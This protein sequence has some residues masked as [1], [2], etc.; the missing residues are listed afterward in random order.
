[1]E[2]SCPALGC[3]TI[4]AALSDAESI[5]N[6]S[7]VDLAT[8]E[9]QVTYNDPDGSFGSFAWYADAA[10]TTPLNAATAFAYSGNGCD[11]QSVTAYLGMTC[12]LQANPI[13]AGNLVVSIYPDFSAT[14]LTETVGNCS[15]PTLTTTCANYVI[16]AVNVPSSVNAGDSGNAEWTVTYSDGSGFATCFS[17]TVNVEYS[18]PALGC[19]TIT[20]A[21][22]D[23]ESICNGDAINLTSYEAQVTYNDPD[24]SFGSFAWYAD[25]AL[26]TPLNAATAF[27]YSGNGCDVQ[28]VTAYL[29]MTCSLQANPIAAGSLT[30][31]IYPDFSASLLTETVG[32]CSVPTLTTTCAN[33]VLTPVNVPATVNA[34][35]SGNAEWTVTYSDGS[36]FATCFNETVNVAYSCPALGCPTITAALSD[37]ESICN[38]DAINLTSYEALVTYNDPD[39]SFG[40]FAW[41]ADAALTTPLNAATAFAYSGNGCDVQSV[42]A[43]L[44]MTCSLQ[45]NPIAAGSLTVTIYPDFSAS[46]LTET[47][48]NCSVPTLTTTCA[49][50]VITAVNVPATVNAGDSG[51]AEWTVTYGDGSGFATCFSETVNVAYS[52]PALPCPEAALT[53]TPDICLGEAVIVTFTGTAGA[54]ATFSCQIGTQTFTGA[55]P[56][57]YTPTVAGDLTVTLTVT[58]NGCDDVAT[59]TVAVADCGCVA[60]PVPTALVNSLI[61]CSGEVNTA[62]FTLTAA[63]NT[64][65]NWYNTSL[66]GSPIATGTSFVPTVAGIYYAE[67][68]NVPDDGCV[69]ARIPFVFQVDVVSLGVTVQGGTII[70]LGSS[71]VLLAN[72]SSSLS[73]DITYSWSPS[74][75][76]SCANCANPTATPTETTTYMVTAVDEFGCSATASVTITVFQENKSILPNAFSPNGDGVDDIFHVTGKNIVSVDLYIYNRW[77]NEVYTATDISTEEGWDGKYKGMDVEIAVFVYYANVRYSDGKEEFLRGNVTVVR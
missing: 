42:T 45:A 66:G 4:T 27:A 2:Y 41:Y 15:V 12:S 62:A 17:Q 68:V 72:A 13:A 38:G 30:V 16:T 9:A 10:L 1:V 49:N 65:I 75:T 48:G 34:G 11:V 57:T 7:T 19:P 71:V 55:G 36:G 46:L 76:L 77:G 52:C 51:N 60:P 58:E 70:E 61:V 29:G 40:S 6:G 39:G 73:G 28:S 24:G 32:N 3:P 33:Y 54:G 8:Y 35:D 37:A 23:A 63:P 64:S 69:S 25:A 59:A 5:C 31:T 43:Y 44:G 56:Y 47:V 14:L 50:Y 21:L 67:A 26:T 20:A 18:C 53:A 22:S 74:A